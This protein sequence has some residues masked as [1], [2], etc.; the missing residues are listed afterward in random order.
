MRVVLDTN[1]LVSALLKRHGN[2][3]LVLTATLG[4]TFELDQTIAFW[5]A[6]KPA[7]RTT[8]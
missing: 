1:V 6:P 5:S 3:A 7:G 8:W 2:E 4:G